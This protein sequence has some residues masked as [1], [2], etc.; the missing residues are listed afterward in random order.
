MTNSTTKVQHLKKTIAAGLMTGVA[1][2][3]AATAHADNTSNFLDYA[4]GQGTG[5]V[6][7]ANILVVPGGDTELISLAKIACAAYDS[8]GGQAAIAA[9]R[10]KQP[11]IAIRNKDPMLVLDAPTLLEI[12]AV[13]YYCPWL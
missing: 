1:L 5:V 7:D 2:L 12:R 4:H 8:Q 10:A 11:N 6:A 13:N 9:V 3:G